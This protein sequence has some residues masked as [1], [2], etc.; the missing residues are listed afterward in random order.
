MNDLPNAGSKSSVAN[1]LLNEN[2]NLVVLSEDLHLDEYIPKSSPKEQ[3][4]SVSEDLS[5]PDSSKQPQRQTQ[6]HSEKSW[7]L[8]CF[9]VVLDLQIVY[10]ANIVFFHMYTFTLTDKFCKWD[11]YGKDIVDFDWFKVSGKGKSESVDF[12]N[13]IIWIFIWLQICTKD[14]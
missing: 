6:T 9:L 7:W 4:R 8:A 1:L 13:K 14:N 5:A 12:K 2:P 3:D 10:K 11:S